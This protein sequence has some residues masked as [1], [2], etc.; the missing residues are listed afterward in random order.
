MPLNLVWRWHV[1]SMSR[2]FL[3][4]LH[5]KHHQQGQKFTHDICS[6]SRQRGDFLY[7]VLRVTFRALNRW[8]PMFRLPLMISFD[9][10]CPQLISIEIILINPK[11]T[12]FLTDFDEKFK[13]KSFC[14]NFQNFNE[15]FKLWILASLFWPLFISFYL[16]LPH[17]IKTD[18]NW[19]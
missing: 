6:T 5:D 11:K 9:L 1:C 8:K 13:K 2:H 14:Q 4:T 16:I 19:S 7:E 3:S 17:L 18:F 10:I 15:K 12:H